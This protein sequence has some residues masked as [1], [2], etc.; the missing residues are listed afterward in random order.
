MKTHTAGFTLLEMIA[1]LG[2][3]SV[4]IVIFS[5]TFLNLLNA[6]RKTQVAA[7]VQDNL[8]F[9]LE[10]MAKEIRTGTEYAVGPS[11]PTACPL[12]SGVAGVWAS[13]AFSFKNADNPPKPFTYRLNDPQLNELCGEEGRR[14]IGKVVGTG[15]A[16]KFLSLT[17]KEITIDRLCFYLAGDQPRVTIVMNARATIQKVETR[18]N[19]QTTVSQRKVAGQ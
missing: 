15:G 6:E 17:S 9:A 16:E 1:A 12:S 19:I 2:V 3:F 4:I 8:R 14:C 10:V 7:S 11:D 5:S 13:A 18:L